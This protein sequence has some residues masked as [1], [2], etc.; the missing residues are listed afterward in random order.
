MSG[1]RN[2]TVGTESDPAL[3]NMLLHVRAVLMHFGL[4]MQHRKRQKWRRG[5]EQ[6]K[7]L[8]QR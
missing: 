1:N 7:W 5:S 6:R 8:K 3:G 2:T 4:Y